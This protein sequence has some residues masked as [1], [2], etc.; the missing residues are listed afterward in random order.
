MTGD[1]GP[2]PGESASGSVDSHR[3]PQDVRELVGLG[4]AEAVP[5][6]SHKHH[7]HCEPSAGVHQLFKG[8]PG[9][10]DRQPSSHQHAVNVKQEAE[11]RLRLRL[12]R[13]VE[14]LAVGEDKRWTST[15][16]QETPSAGGQ[17]SVILLSCKNDD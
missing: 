14:T 11:A 5:C 3:H 6:I 2:S 1:P 7:R 12:Y 16:H 13:E 9:R 17:E 8:L 15:G 4:L 10:G